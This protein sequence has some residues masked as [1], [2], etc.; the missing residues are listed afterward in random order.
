MRRPIPLILGGI[1]IVSVA[2]VVDISG[3]PLAGLVMWVVGVVVGIEGAREY[4][5]LHNTGVLK[6]DRTTARISIRPLHKISSSKS[7]MGI[8]TFTK[9]G[10]Q[11]RSK[12]EAKIAEYLSDN[13]IEWEY[14]PLLL[15]GKEELARP[16]FYLRKYRIL[17]EYWGLFGDDGYDR[18]MKFKLDEYRR[19]GYDVISI[20]PDE[21]DNLDRIFRAKFEKVTG[22]RFP[23]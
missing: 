9:A 5:E 15:S 6:T 10:V 8:P 22:L 13:N 3:Q 2:A 4:Y 16:D 18:R 19:H 17:V 12:A 14:E 7:E 11:V 21:L 23:N 20:Y 1:T